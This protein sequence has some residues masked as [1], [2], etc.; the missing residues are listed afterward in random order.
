MNEPQLDPHHLIE[1]PMPTM[2]PHHPV[3]PNPVSV[4]GFG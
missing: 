3:R 2:A 4:I 1:A